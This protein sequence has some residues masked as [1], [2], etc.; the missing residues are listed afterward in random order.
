MSVYRTL[1]QL[2]P[3]VAGRAALALDELHYKGFTVFISETYRTQAT[4]D[5]YY[6]QGRKTV[7]EVN[8]LRKLAGL[9]P[10]TETG[11]ITHAQVSKHTS[12]KALDIY[13][14]DIKSNPLWNATRDQ[15]LP[16]ANAFK[17]QGFDWGGD[18]TKPDANGKVFVDLPHFEFNDV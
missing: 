16:I 3:K 13:P 11:V 8:V 4:Q 12:R 17:A 5:A 18:W 6:A 9:Q 1:D 2:L 15:F 7:D 10:T 14:V